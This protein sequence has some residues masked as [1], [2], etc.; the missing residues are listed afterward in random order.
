MKARTWVIGAILLGLMP[1]GLVGQA[2]KVARFGAILKGEVLRSTGVQSVRW[3]PGSRGY[4]EETGD[5]SGGFVAI[6]PRTGARSAVFTPPVLAKL[7]AEFPGPGLPF[8]RF[9]LEPIG[10]ALR[11]ESGGRP[12]LFRT[13]SLVLHRLA[14]PE[15]VGPLDLATAEPGKYSPN[16][17]HYAFIRDY[18]NLVLFDTETGAEELIVRGTS[19]DNLIGFLGAGPWFVWSP[20]GRRIAYL[21]ADQ[22]GFH[23]YPILRDL[24]R[25]ATVE[26][27]RYPFTVDPDP[28]LE[29]HVYDLGTKQDVVVAKSSPA[30]PFIRDLEWVPDGSELTY[31]VVSRFENRLELKG[32]DPRTASGR[33]WLVDTSATY[34][35]PPNNFRVLPDGRFLWSSERSGWR[36]LELYDRQ[37]RTRRQ[38]TSGE[39]VV[40]EVVGVDDKAGLVYFTGVTNLGLEQHLFRVRLD[41]T[42]LTQVTR[43]P[44]WHEV[45]LSPDLVAFVD[46]HSSLSAPP[47]VTMREIDGRAVRPM[48]TSDPTQLKALGLAPPELM[49]FRGADGTTPI[50]GLLFR[51]AD[52]DP[53]TRYPVIVSVYGGPHT[54][55]I[56]DRFETTDF[57]AALAQLNFLVFEVDARG[58]LGRG[59]AF[60][61]GNYLGM[62]Q[63]DVDDQ[64]AA[65]RQLGRLPFVDSTR[66]GVTGISHGGYLTLM[67]VLRY[68]D[69]F[70]VGVAGAPITDLRNGPRQYIGRIMR[71]P[72][73]NPDGYDRGNVL[74]L[75]AGL[76]SRLL[77]MYGTND[78][79]A[80]V[81]NTMQLARKL[82]DAGRPF[83][84][85]V[86][87]AG[88]HVLGGA[89]GIHGLKTT[90]SYFLEHLRPE[91]WEA[92]RAALW[93]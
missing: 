23:Q 60:Q 10:T 22:R 17:R 83:D 64:A 37:G 79:N 45:S 69:V 41:G 29:L 53:A 61:S 27:F 88:D 31:Q 2:A 7:R 51:P 73:A 13:D 40:G 21:K 55:A 72:D 24:D 9:D 11:F 84:M 18:D 1:A 3:L 62:G 82:I 76:R 66:V 92:S 19:E 39:W 26:R 48:A 15:K 90:V 20:D 14:M 87:P 63:V 85:A 34:L 67:M 78:H 89:D 4:L 28:P 91:G 44:G 6:N 35:D 75:A 70:Q 81:A 36:H 86:Y 47:T 54:K 57:R 59:K 46:R 42:G 77:I 80:V 33:T 30:L 65:V 5:A 16:W 49:T 12:Y 43:D 93:Q 52:F 68:P 71:T 58:T 74:G 32:F 50:Q 8:T 25:K 56:R 38:L